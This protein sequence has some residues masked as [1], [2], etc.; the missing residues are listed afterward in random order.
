VTALSFAD[1]QASENRVF[2]LGRISDH[3]IVG[4]NRFPRIQPRRTNLV[5]LLE[6]A[7]LILGILI[8][9]AV[10]TTLFVVILQRLAVR[11]IR[12]RPNNRERLD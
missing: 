8:V 7:G 3:G 9:P 4:S 6:D 12:P 10:L 1:V 11:Q 5:V 2:D